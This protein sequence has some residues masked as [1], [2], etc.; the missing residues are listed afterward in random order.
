MSVSPT[1][2]SIPDFDPLSLAA[3]DVTV[4]GPRE[5]AP[6]PPSCIDATI[7]VAPARPEP[8]D[9]TIDH[10]PGQGSLDGSSELD[11][12]SFAVEAD[13]CQVQARAADSTD[14]T[15]DHQPSQVSLDGSSE[16]DG[17]SFALDADSCRVQ[18]K[19]AGSTDLTIDHLPTQASLEGSSELDEG[20]SFAMDEGSGRVRPEAQHAVANYEILGVL[21]RGAAGVVYKARHIGLKRI[22][23]LKMLLS[24]VHASQRELMRFNIEA[25]AVA[26][27]QHPNIV[28]VYEIGAQDGL[29]FFSLEYVEGGSLAQR[30]AGKPLPTQEAARLSEMLARAMHYSHERKIL[31]R[32]LKPANILVTLDG[33]P[34]ITDFGLAKRLEATE[35]SSKTRTGTLMGTPS[36]MSPEQAEGRT[37]DVGPKS[38]QYALGAI[39]Y[40]ML[41]GRPP[42]LGATLLDTLHQVRKQEP[43]PPSRLLHKAPRDLEIICLK[44]LQKE[45]AKRYADCGELADDLK[46]FGA[47][48]PIRARAVS[49]AERMWRWC[50]RNPRTAALSAAV[51]LLLA[52]LTVSGGILALNIMHEQQAVEKVKED[53]QAQM[54]NASDAISAGDVRRAMDLMDFSD[55]LLESEPALL[56]MRTSWHDLKDRIETYGKFKDLLD[57]AR[58]AYVYGKRGQKEQG[59][60]YCRQLLELYEAIEQRREPAAGGLPPLNAEQQQLFKEDVFDM[61]LLTAL[62][63]NELNINSPPVRQQQVAGQAIDWLD[64]AEKILPGTRT[65]SVHL[66]GF[67][68]RLGHSQQYEAYMA[69]A[70]ATPPTAAIDHFWHGYAEH[71]RG[72]G[73]RSGGNPDEANKHY[74]LEITEYAAM[75]RAFPDH[76]WGYYNWAWA[77]ANLDDL[78]DALIG[79]TNCIRLKPDSP[80]PYNNRG[81][82]HLRLKQYDLAV[83]DYNDALQRDPEYIDARINRALAYLEQGKFDLALADCNWTLERDGQNVAAYGRRAECYR[84][85]KRYEEAIADYTRWLGLTEDKVE[86]YFKRAAVFQEMKRPNDA[87]GDYTL[88]VK[89]EPKNT[90]HYLKR[91]ALYLEMNRPNDALRDYD[92][93]LDLE[94]KNFQAHLMRGKVRALRGEHRQA[95]E[96]FTAAIEARPDAPEPYRDRAVIYWKMLKDFDAALEDWQRVIELGVNTPEAYYYLAEIY[97]GRRQYDLALPQ[98]DK[99]LALQANNMDALWDK[100]QVYL[101]QGKAKEALAVVNPMVEKLPRGTEEMLG[102]RGDIYIRLNRLE[103]AAAD[104]RRL[105]QLRPDLPEAY[106]TL[107]LIYQKQGQPGKAHECLD[108]MVAANLR[109]PTAYLRRGQFLRDRGKFAEAFKDSEQAARYDSGSVLPALLQASIKAARGD[110]AAAVADAGA[111]LKK[112]VPDDGHVLYAAAQIWGLASTAAARAGKAK[113]SQQYADR[114]ADFLAKT[115]DKGY[116]DLLYCEH[117]RMIDDPA[118]ES[119]HQHPRGREL[120]ALSE[121]PPE[122]GALAP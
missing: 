8:A 81:T 93:V 17:A 16:L 84:R 24:G 88:V 37:R 87:L 119:L 117:N 70:R 15:I 36:Y 97:L 63:E 113:L 96:D 114:A 45:P 95:V 61:F 107:A 66:A 91:A 110:H 18:A 53:V 54:K 109:L 62:T 86:V 30:I 1:N 59:R 73:A 71:V 47:G 39:L 32:D 29:P 9:H 56:T 38:D 48:E 120:L 26:R 4:T 31:H 55:P 13:S 43:V 106:A 80:W 19:Q 90:G 82:T 116:H 78:Q 89:L 35:E 21:G 51:L 105:I 44:C 40:E 49:A 104:Y 118:L 50:R 79:F 7:D 65:A 115:L 23:A 101:C 20:A 27:F 28:Q 34:K 33:V 57:R 5:E 68:Q 60:E 121:K 99:A 85:Q 46:R 11:G 6:Q 77:K 108:R 41:T 94:A 98:L 111:I 76:F 10:L 64:R 67:H 58:F 112:A 25:E 69:R 122:R 3:G 102:A 103:E 12:A 2:E 22:T 100:A 74:R 52:L 42:F 92:R 75:L 83:Q 72:D 14:L